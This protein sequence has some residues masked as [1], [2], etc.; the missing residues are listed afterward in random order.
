MSTSTIAR[1]VKARVSL[2]VALAMLFG[3]GVGGVAIMR[4]QGTPKKNAGQTEQAPYKS[5]IQ[6]PDDDKG[7]EDEADEA[8]EA[9]EADEKNEAREQDEAESPKERF[10]A[11]RFRSLARITPAQ[12]RD[13]ALASVPGTAGSV[14]L[15][16]EDGNLVYGVTVKTTAGDR[17]VKVD[18]GNGRVL[19]IETEQD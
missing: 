1:N 13:A 18:A 19:H 14:E 12:A 16:N 8:D 17:D 3:T 15:E 6:V 4:A 11:A 9:K 7:E 2:L 5:S 10:E